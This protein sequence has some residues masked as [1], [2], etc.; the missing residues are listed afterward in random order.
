MRPEDVAEAALL[1]FRRVG[2]ASS[3]WAGLPR[4]RLACAL[5]HLQS[6]GGQHR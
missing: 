5:E 6:P 1:P 3:C 2:P 4:F